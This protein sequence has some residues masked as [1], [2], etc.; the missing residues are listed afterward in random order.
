MPPVNAP[1]KSR[2]WTD[3][4]LQSATVAAGAL[5]DISGSSQVPFLHIVSAICFVILSNV[6]AV[7][8]NKQ[9]CLQM[10]EQINELLW[11]IVDLCVN[12][13]TGDVLPPSI[14]HNIGNLHSASSTQIVPNVP[15]FSTYRTLQKI[16]SYVEGQLKMGKIKRFFRQGE[17]SQQLDECKTGLQHA[18]ELFS[19]QTGATTMAGLAEL[20]KG[21]EA[22]YN[23][24]LELVS[25]RTATI[26]SGN[27]SL[28]TMRGAEHP[29]KASWTRPFLPPLKP[30]TYSAARQTFLDIADDTH[31]D[32]EIDELL[33]LTDHLPLAVNLIANIVSFEGSATVLLRWKNEST[34]LISEA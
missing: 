5:R 15:E 27:F 8:V 28:V 29:G 31:N 10:V 20:Q 6:Q 34:T 2:T 3:N 11:A 4:V 13:K 19:V 14:L 33:R 7:K 24:L 30:L 23:A 1:L 18:V 21:E 9:G 32:A 25:A 26:S 22:R 16:H 12:S 17:N